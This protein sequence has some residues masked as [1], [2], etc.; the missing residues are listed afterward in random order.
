MRAVVGLMIAIT[1]V[2]QETKLIWISDLKHLFVGNLTRWS[3]TFIWSHLRLSYEREKSLLTAAQTLTND[4]HFPST[5][6]STII[7]GRRL[8]GR[9]IAAFEMAS[10]KQTSDFIWPVEMIDVLLLFDNSI[11]L[12]IFS[13]E[14]SLCGSRPCC[15]C[16]YHLSSLPHEIG[17]GSTTRSP[18]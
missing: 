2:C 10:I 6:S 16:R 14:K 18:W 4:F 8:R 1:K 15:C 3:L 13:D 7:Y 12:P 11:S 5:L 17:D 9:E